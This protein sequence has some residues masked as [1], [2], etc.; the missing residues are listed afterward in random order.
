[1]A[2]PEEQEVE[3]E[4]ESSATDDVNAE[5]STEEQSEATEEQAAPE[6]Q[7]VP[8]DRFREVNEEKK[9]LQS[10]VDNLSRQQPPSPQAPVVD[11]D[12]NLDPQ[13][14]VFYQDLDKR[15]QVAITKAREEERI[16]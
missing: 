10:I 11:P 1:M 9:Q 13:T 3:T 15:T 8:Y 7:T 4:V 2:D 5:S 12:A 14:K 6:E 16:Q